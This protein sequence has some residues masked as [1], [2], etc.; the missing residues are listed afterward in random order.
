[1]VFFQQALNGVIQGCIYALTALGLSL[2]FGILQISNFAHGEFYMLGAFTALFCT[3]SLHMP[4]WAAMLLSMAVMALFCIVVERVIFRPI[5]DT[6]LINSMIL[7]FGL[8][9]ALANLAL[10]FFKADPRRIS[11]GLARMRI[12]FC[13]L[14]LTGER[15]AVLLIS[16]VLVAAVAWFIKSCRMGK[17]MRAVAQ[18]RVAA[19]LAGINVRRV[20]SATFALSGALAAAA[21]TMVG[22]MFFVS[23]EMGFTVILKC[24]IIVTLGGT[25]SILGVIAAAVLIGLVESLGG[26]FISYAYKDAYPFLLMLLLFIFRP[27]GLKGGGD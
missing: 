6:P 22:A 26:G 5:V 21:G 11:S 16:L 9:S 10:F 25:E 24:F 2:T 13:G 23:P 8:S 3:A 7:S 27:E 15:L 4:F 1:M 19:Q 12:R 17:A 20:Y 18:D 14:F